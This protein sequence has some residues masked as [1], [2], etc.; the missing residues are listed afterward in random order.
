MY[1][2][3]SSYFFKVTEDYLNNNYKYILYIFHL[4]IDS[5]FFSFFFLAQFQAEVGEEWLIEKR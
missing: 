5:V 2:G 3:A 4:V 1:L